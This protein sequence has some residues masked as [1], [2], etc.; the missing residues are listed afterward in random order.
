MKSTCIV[1]EKPIGS[2]GFV[3]LHRRI[4]MF[5]KW[6]QSPFVQISVPSTHS[7]C[8]SFKLYCAHAPLVFAREGH[9]S[10]SIPRV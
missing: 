10:P 3:D 9:C 8:K 5:V 4:F 7:V 2:V 1:K 6:L